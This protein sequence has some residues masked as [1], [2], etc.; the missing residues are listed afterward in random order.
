MYVAEN[1]SISFF[2]MAKY[3]SSVHMYHMFFI[4]SS[5]NGHLGYFCVLAIVNRAAVDIGVQV[6]FRISFIWI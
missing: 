5:V 6:S 3:Y 1:G 2:F 4:H